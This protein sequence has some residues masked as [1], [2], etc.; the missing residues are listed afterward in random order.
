MFFKDEVQLAEGVTCGA[1]VVVWLLVVVCVVV[2][3][4]CGVAVFVSLSWCSL[5]VFLEVVVD[6]SKERE[7]FLEIGFLFVTMFG[8]VGKDLEHAA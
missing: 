6:F 2:I 4:W 7:G 1:V 5:V 8:A 3:V